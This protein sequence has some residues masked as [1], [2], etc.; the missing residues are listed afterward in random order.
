MAVPGKSIAMWM[1]R[2]IGHSISRGFENGTEVSATYKNISLTLSASYTYQRAMDKTTPNGTTYN[3]QLPYTPRHSG[4]FIISIETPR[5]GACINSFASG[6]YYSNSYNGKEYRMD[7]YS[8][9]GAV[10]WY[11]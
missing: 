1:M 2:N 9:T 5:I 8:E 11:S 4:S 10:L 7:A 6:E 3:H